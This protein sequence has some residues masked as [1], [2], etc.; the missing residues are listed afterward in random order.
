[1]KKFIR[2]MKALA[3]P[4][5]TRI[6]KL[7]QKKCLCVADI[8]DAVNLKQPSVSKHLKILENA[9]L[10]C[11]QK[12]GKRI[13]YKITNGEDSPYAAV[14]LGNLRHWLEEAGIG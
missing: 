5:R 12:K 4:N 6:L 3:D 13:C 8:T 11:S 14:M 9:G 1:M 10:V 7:L 2:V